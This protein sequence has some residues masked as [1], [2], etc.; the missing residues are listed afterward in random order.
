MSDTSEEIETIEAPETPAALTLWRK[1]LTAWLVGLFA[2][3]SYLSVGHLTAGFARAGGSGAI[4]NW[5]PFLP[6]TVWIYLPM[7]ALVFHVAVF[8]VKTQ[9]TLNRTIASLLIVWAIAYAVFVI[10]PL[11]GPRIHP[12]AGGDWTTWFL[13]I[14]QVVDPPNNTFPSLHAANLVCVALGCYRDDRTGGTIVLAL[15]LLPITATVTTKQHYAVDLFGGVAL[16]ALAHWMAF[17]GAR[18]KR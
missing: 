9:Q 4:D 3:V 14:L 18:S 2:T 13:G 10:Y 15:S 7:Y 17:A 8:F 6:W 11:N 12:A 5:I 1:F 16:A